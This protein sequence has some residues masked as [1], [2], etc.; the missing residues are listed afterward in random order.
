MYLKE[1]R[2]FACVRLTAADTVEV[3][4]RE[5]WQLMVRAFTRLTPLIEAHRAS[6]ALILA[7]GGCERLLLRGTTPDRDAI[8]QVWPLLATAVTQMLAEAV[9]SQRAGQPV[10]MVGVGPTRTLAWLASILSSR[11]T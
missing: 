10:G 2:P 1:I 7:L 5:Q 11:G 3:D 4:V 6:R 9:S 8:E